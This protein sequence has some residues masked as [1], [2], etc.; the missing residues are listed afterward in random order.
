[1]ESPVGILDHNDFY[2]PELLRKK[3]SPFFAI[4]TQHNRIER[5]GDTFRQGFFRGNFELPQ[6]FNLFLIKRIA[7]RG[8]FGLCQPEIHSWTSFD[9][10]VLLQ[11]T[12]N[13][14][15]VSIPARTHIS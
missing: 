3:R 10:E 5:A 14:G 11:T 15:G 6:H 12:M 1:M 4:N 8:N 7:E 9:V 2:I 13:T